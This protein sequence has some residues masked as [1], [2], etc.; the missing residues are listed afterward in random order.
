MKYFVA[1]DG[2][3]YT[4]SN[5]AHR[6]V[7]L[8]DSTGRYEYELTGLSTVRCLEFL[9]S[10][11][12]KATPMA[13]GWNYDVN[14]ILRDLDAESLIRLKKEGSVKWQTY[15][16]EWIP[17]KWFVVKSGKR[18][19]KVSDAFGFFQTS[20]VNALK[21]WDIPL[22]DGMEEMKADR[23]DFDPSRKAE[24]IDYCL[25]ECRSLVTLMDELE[26]A[27]DEVGL[28]LN[29]W[30]G[31][32]SIASALMNKEGVKYYVTADSEFSEPIYNA[33]RYSYF[34]GRSELFL[35]G[36]F[37][38]LWDYDIS[39]AYPSVARCLPALPNGTWVNRPNFNESDRYC[40][41]RCRWQINNSFL[42]RVPLTPF[43]FRKTANRG[44]I[45]YPRNGEGWYH[46]VEVTAAQRIFGEQIEVLEC[47]QFQPSTN[48]QPFSFIPEMFEHRAQ[49][50]REG[51]AGEKVLKLGLNAIY[52]KLAQG[53]GYM[54]KRPPFQSY[55]WAGLIT[56]TTRARI[57]DIASLA[58]KNLVMVATDGIFFNC[59]VDVDLTPGLGGLELTEME[60]VFVA[61]P[62]VYQAT[63]DGETVGRSRGFFS[64]EIDFDDLRAGFEREGCM[65]VGKYESTRFVG[66]GSAL[67]T[68][69][70]D[71]W[72]KWKTSERQLSLYPSR[73]FVLDEGN[74]TNPLRHRAATMPPG[75]FS[76]PYTPKRSNSP[77]DGDEL[78]ALV[79]YLQGSEQPLESY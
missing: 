14:M 61:Q 13:F 74:K 11:P 15:F 34:G 48:Q 73:K 39:S 69:N 31:A 4:T 55:F 45:Y 68:R 6:Y 9:L 23:S 1:V 12:P 78:A 50:K 40:L 77:L 26:M 66:L 21:K 22:P 67:L 8:A 42:E 64:R 75:A 32:G 65:Y 59:P 16:L 28:K 24:I 27:L 29:S 47:W 37:P 35:Q 46:G 63:V 57:L 17:S 41:V 18:R 54:G 25:S 19:R 51:R 70:L 33:L 52:G 56:A 10:L 76:F 2:E 43:P 5:G 30:V 60:N 36:S 38:R 44:D 49:L 7:L 72:R 58:P 79:E 3:S 20:F 71:S 53:Y 62:G